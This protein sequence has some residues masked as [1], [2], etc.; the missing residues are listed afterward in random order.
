MT[1]N[2]EDFINPISS[3][4]VNLEVIASFNVDQVEKLWNSLQI[5]GLKSQEE[6]SDR[7]I[8]NKCLEVLE[9]LYRKPWDETS[10]IVH[11]I[12][13]F[14]IFLILYIVFFKIIQMRLDQLRDDKSHLVQIKRLFS[15]LVVT[16][17]LL[18]KN[19]T[20][21]LLELKGAFHIHKMRDCL[22]LGSGSGCQEEMMSQLIS[23]QVEIFVECKRK[24]LSIN[25]QI[26]P[27]VLELFRTVPST[28]TKSLQFGKEFESLL[29]ECEEFR[30]FHVDLLNILTEN[31]LNCAIECRRNMKQ[32]SEMITDAINW[33]VRSL[34]L[35]PNVM[36]YFE[37]L[38]L[39]RLQC[40][41]T[42][43]NSSDFDQAI[44]TCL[45]TLKNRVNPNENIRGKL[46]IIRLIVAETGK[47]EKGI[48]FACELFANCDFNNCGCFIMEDLL[49]IIDENSS[50]NSSSSPIIKLLERFSDQVRESKQSQTCIIETLLRLTE[51]NFTVKGDFQRA[52]EIFKV[53]KNLNSDSDSTS[54]R[55]KMIKC[56]LRLDKLSEAE[57]ELDLMAGDSLQLLLLKLEAALR[58][59]NEFDSLSFIE[60]ILENSEG[61]SE[62]FLGLFNLLKTRLPAELQMKLL[63]AAKSSDDKS[64]MIIDIER[65]IIGLLYDGILE[66]GLTEEYK[67]E[68]DN[69]LH[70]SK[71]TGMPIYYQ[72]L[73]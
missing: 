21:R 8:K 17:P 35:R 30:E 14:I 51:K 1:I 27:K 20:K 42:V 29:P 70:S 37:F 72:M 6:S 7:L 69:C 3:K 10:N 67:T 4:S 41:N 16:C 65:G 11:L 15:E 26:G 55:L 39:T 46:Q 23:E 59:Q 32:F 13:V 40:G 71:Y 63:Q 64:G 34:A 44:E 28:T 60:K 47:L 52:E 38:K 45:L 73:L 22:G 36:G 5:K 68:L 53:I 61:R 33:N 9:K 49:C 24:G 54:L 56:C 12:S 48:E 31:T 62:H 25:N 50:N 43:G 19:Q 57:S 66:S 58:S 18:P 2:I